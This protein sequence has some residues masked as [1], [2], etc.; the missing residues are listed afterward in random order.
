[1]SSIWWL[2]VAPL[3]VRDKFRTWSSMLALLS[4]PPLA[5]P[6]GTLWSWTPLLSTQ[7]NNNIHVHIQYLL[8]HPLPETLL[9]LGLFFK[10]QDH[11]T[12]NIRNLKVNR[13][14]I[15]LNTTISRIHFKMRT[16]G[17]V[18]RNFFTGVN[19]ILGCQLWRDKRVLSWLSH[20]WLVVAFLHRQFTWKSQALSSKM[21]YPSIDWIMSIRGKSKT[22]KT[23]NNTYSEW[24]P[25]RRLPPLAEVESTQPNGDGTAP[26]PALPAKFKRHSITSRIN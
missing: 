5:L 23:N 14:T 9:L 1:M 16:R 12:G 24:E 20:G 2:M 17:K 26:V 25:I 22:N 15:P 6:I 21:L 10:C 11:T 3:P 13:G 8:Q 19:L 18:T 7:Q 4:L